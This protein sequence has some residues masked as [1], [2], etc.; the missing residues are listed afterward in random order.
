MKNILDLLRNVRENASIWMI[1]VSFVLLM[2]IYGEFRLFLL[3]FDIIIV[4]LTLRAVFDFT[5]IYVDLI[6]QI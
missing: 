3:K 2:Q 1:T 5:N 4:N 6:P